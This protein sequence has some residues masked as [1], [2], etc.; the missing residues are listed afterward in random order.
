MGQGHTFLFVEGWRPQTR[1]RSRRP[2][3]G[4]SMGIARAM[5]VNGTWSHGDYFIKT[6]RIEQQFS[7]CG[8]FAIASELHDEILSCSG[9]ALRMTCCECS[10][11]TDR[12]EMSIDWRESAGT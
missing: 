11:S 5:D 3:F 8:L 6:N 12:S 2:G 7:F 9:V 10:L 4:F 1:E